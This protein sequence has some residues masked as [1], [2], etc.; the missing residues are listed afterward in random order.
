MNFI[1]IVAFWWFKSS[2][3]ATLV[4]V[5]VKIAKNGFVIV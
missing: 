3:S 5:A 2:S 1:K 4:L